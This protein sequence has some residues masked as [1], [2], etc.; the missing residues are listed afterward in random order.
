MKTASEIRENGE[1]VGTPGNFRRQRVA[2]PE[3]LLHR[4]S[5]FFRKPLMRK[6]FPKKHTASDHVDSSSL[7]MRARTIQAGIFCL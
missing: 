5:D 3:F 2:P 6:E 4:A 1:F 7:C